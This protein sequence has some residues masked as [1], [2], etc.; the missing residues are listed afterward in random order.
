MHYLLFIYSIISTEICLFE[1]N[2]HTPKCDLF[3]LYALIQ[4]PDAFNSHLN[5]YLFI[6]FFSLCVVVINPFAN[7]FHQHDA[8]IQCKH[9]R[10]KGMKTMSRWWSFVVN[11]TCWV[12]YVYILRMAIQNNDKVLMLHWKRTIDGRFVEMSLICCDLGRRRVED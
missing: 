4:F 3:V 11:G 2:L 12:A 7:R 8:F 9:K 10:S 5:D 6:H 1:V